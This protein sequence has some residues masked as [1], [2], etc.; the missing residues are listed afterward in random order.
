M[1]SIPD[2]ETCVDGDSECFRYLTDLGR[3]VLGVVTAEELERDE[4]YD[5]EFIDLNQLEV[6][7]YANKA[8]IARV[9]EICD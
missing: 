4:W 9:G 8:R 1:H 2:I 3:Y 5:A 7:A 6:A